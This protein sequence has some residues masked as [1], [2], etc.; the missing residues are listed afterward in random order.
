MNK[1]NIFVH[2]ELSKLV[3]NLTTN[4][5]LSKEYLKSQAGYFNIIPPKYFS[6][7]LSPEWQSIIEVIKHK[8]PKLDESGRIVSN[9]VLNT[10]EQMS[11]EECI[12]LAMRII[13]LRDKVM[14]EF[15]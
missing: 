14:Q 5:L 9:A 4:I 1:S 15:E 2:I 7:A 10:I 11:S 12:A 13:S 3:A 6:D 8:G